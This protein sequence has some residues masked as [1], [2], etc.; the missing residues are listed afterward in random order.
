MILIYYY[1]YY[2]L[3]LILRYNRSS[4]PDCGKKYKIYN[5]VN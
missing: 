5:V 2:N 4:D 1:I 3:F